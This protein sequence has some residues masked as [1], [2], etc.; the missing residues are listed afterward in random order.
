LNS[1]PPLSC[2]WP[3]FTVEK[4]TYLKWWTEFLGILRKKSYHTPLLKMK[5]PSTLKELL[6]FEV[7]SRHRYVK[8]QLGDS[9]VIPWG[10]HGQ[11]QAYFLQYYSMVL[12]RPWF[13][14]W[15]NLFVL[16]CLWKPDIISLVFYQSTAIVTYLFIYFCGL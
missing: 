13:W 6:V 15:I 16:Y 1:L 12:C 4:F 9:L 8:I 2:H 3:F 11:S 10:L 7:T 5:Q 14:L